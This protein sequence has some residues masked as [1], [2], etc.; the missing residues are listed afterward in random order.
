[1]LCFFEVNNTMKTVAQGCNYVYRENMSV[2][3]EKCA[4]DRLLKNKKH[5]E[6]INKS[7]NLLVVRLTKTGI[8]GESRPCYHCLLALQNSG[9]KIKYVYYS[10]NEGKIVRERFSEMLDSEITYISLGHRKKLYNHDVSEMELRK[11]I[12]AHEF[13]KK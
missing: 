10:T 7:F 2:H 4:L 8:I 12:Y 9:L 1:M 5:R 6:K 13:I 3:A 11:P